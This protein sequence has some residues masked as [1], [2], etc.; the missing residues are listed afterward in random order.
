MS[1]SK[2]QNFQV[3]EMDAGANMLNFPNRDCAHSR[4][5]HGSH[6]YSLRNGETER[7]R[8]M[9]E[10]VINTLGSVQILKNNAILREQERN[11]SVNNNNGT[12]TGQETT[13]NGG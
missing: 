13:V 12:S 4:N 8:D 11:N 3:L 5:G 10:S 9:R 7:E 2:I 1:K 6:S